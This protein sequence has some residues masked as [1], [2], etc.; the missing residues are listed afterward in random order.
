MQINSEP[1]GSKSHGETVHL[2]KSIPP[3]ARTLLLISRA[4][5]ETKR[6]E[7]KNRSFRSRQ[8]PPPPL[9]AAQPLPPQPLPHSNH[10]MTSSRTNPPQ[11][12]PLTQPRMPLT[13][14]VYG[15]DSNRISDHGSVQSGS[16]RQHHQL[17]ESPVRSAG[18]GGWDPITQFNQGANSWDSVSDY[19]DLQVSLQ[20]DNNGFGFK[21][22]LRY[23][24]LM[25]VIYS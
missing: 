20:K 25:E 24:F 19:Q 18:S 23:V 5:P 6:K 10:V 11:I 15:M 21:V 12:N 2:L 13:V 17:W 16:D 7:K 3:H 4:D 1:L 14:P 9:T 22:S 8:P